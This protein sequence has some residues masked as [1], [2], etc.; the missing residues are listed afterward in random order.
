MVNTA[1]GIHPY[2]DRFLLS[3][4]FSCRSCL[5]R[6]SRHRPAHED[7]P[8]QCSGDEAEVSHSAS[9]SGE[10]Y[11]G[12]YTLVEYSSQVAGSLLYIVL[13]EIIPP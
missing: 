9:R 3:V 8:K 2:F 7:E 11:C 6:A 5:R 1:I 13:S 10:S 4:V 12:I